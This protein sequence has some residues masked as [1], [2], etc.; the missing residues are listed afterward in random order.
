MMH[1]PKFIPTLT[2]DGGFGLTSSDLLAHEVSCVA[3]HLSALLMKPGAL[4]LNQVPSWAS[5]VNWSQRF[6]LNAADLKVD[7]DG[8]CLIRSR[9]DGKT[10][11]YAVDDLMRLIGHLNPTMLILPAGCFER[12]IDVLP[13]SMALFVAFDELA[14]YGD[15][16]RLKGYYQYIQQGIESHGIMAARLHYRHLQA[17]WIIDDCLSLNHGVDDLTWLESG[18][19]FIDALLG[20]VYTQQ[21]RL[22]L[23]DP[24]FEFEFSCID[25]SC[26]CTTCASGLTCAYLHHLYQQTPGL[27]QRFLI[28][29]NLYQIMHPRC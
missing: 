3:Y 15:H 11:H 9:Y 1:T 20:V 10:S 23:T 4:V 29:H 28:Q 24:A 14:T 17:Y 25:S 19:P 7:S 2:V 27:C 8:Q 13:S 5:Y 12:A 18:Q 21:R 6:V 22:Y 16:P 26:Q